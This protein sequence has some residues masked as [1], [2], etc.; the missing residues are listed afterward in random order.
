MDVPQIFAEALYWFFLVAWSFFS[1]YL[2]VVR[3]V[4]NRLANR[5]GTLLFGV[6]AHGESSASHTHSTHPQAPKDSHV[7]EHPPKLFAKSH[8]SHS[9]AHGGHAH[10]VHT[11]PPEVFPGGAGRGDAIDEFIVAQLERTK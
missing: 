5:L 9:A 1:V 2:I 8:A 4:Q 6:E 7:D 11:E 3:Q 10:A